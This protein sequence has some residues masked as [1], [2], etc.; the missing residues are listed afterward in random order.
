M[1]ISVC[2]TTTLPPPQ[3]Q[4]HYTLTLESCA[5]RAANISST[6]CAAII[7]AAV[8]SC[9]SVNTFF[10]NIVHQSR[11]LLVR[12]QDGKKNLDNELNFLKYKHNL[13]S[14]QSCSTFMGSFHEI[15]LDNLAKLIKPYF[16]FSTFNCHV[17]L[18]LLKSINYFLFKSACASIKQLL[19]SVRDWMKKIEVLPILVEYIGETSAHA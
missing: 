9:R 6:T 5:P 16:S 12:A 4:S 18:K 8:C 13:V 10:Y 7:G 14:L 11:D 2:C 3:S 17:N 19:L 15:C 1:L